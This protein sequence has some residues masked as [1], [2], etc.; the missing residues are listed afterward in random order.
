MSKGFR[1]GVI[2]LTLI[3]VIL[4]SVLGVATAKK[5]SDLPFGN[6]VEIDELDK[7]GDQVGMVNILVLGVDLEGYRSD[8]IMLFSYDGYSN[9]VNVISIPRDTRIMVNGHYQKINSAIGV[10]YQNVRNGIDNEPEE[11][12]IRQVKELTGLPINYFLT[13][14]F[15]GFIDVINALGGVDF[16]VPYDMNYDDPVQNLHIHLKAGQQH[17]D[18]KGAHD[19]VRFRQNNDHSAPGEYVMGDVGRIHWQQEFV[20]ELIRQKTKPQ[21][22]SKITEVY[23]VVAENLRTNFKMQDLLKYIDAIQEMNINQIETY[24]LPGEAAYLPD[25]NENYISWY[26]CDDR[27]TL[28]LVHDVFLPKS[29]EEFAKEQAEVGKN[30]E[31]EPQTQNNEQNKNK[32]SGNSNKSEN[33]KVSVNFD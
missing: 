22:L 10:G 9:R 4:F 13:V 6:E 23:D 15:S 26:I 2:L 5:V 8:T 19:F 20:K 29:A 21:Y 30:N 33:K 14:D 24:Q 25:E 27:K 18:G 16:N 3:C 28:E 12:L 31:P 1:V 17:L 11:E 32:Q 7:T